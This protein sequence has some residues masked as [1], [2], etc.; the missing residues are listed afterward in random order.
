MP[1]IALYDWE[2]DANAGDNDYDNDDDNYSDNDYK[3]M[4]TMM[5]IKPTK[6]IFH[7]HNSEDVVD[8]DDDGGNGTDGDDD[9]GVKG[10]DHDADVDDDRL[11]NDGMMTTVMMSDKMTTMMII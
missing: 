10:D 11:D 5:M 7:N 1:S 4:M 3:L 2:Y 6:N 9:D 8:Y